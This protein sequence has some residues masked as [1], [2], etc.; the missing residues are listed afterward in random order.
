MCHESLNICGKR[1]RLHYVTVHSKG[2]EYRIRV[3]PGLYLQ[4]RRGSAKL[5]R[6]K[7]FSKQEITLWKRIE[8]TLWAWL[9]WVLMTIVT[10]NITSCYSDKW[11]SH[12]QT[13]VCFVRVLLAFSTKESL[14][15]SQ[16]M[17]V[18]QWRYNSSAY[19]KRCTYHLCVHD[20]FACV[21]WLHNVP[22]KE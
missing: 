17:Y 8:L 15:K 12:T 21:E 7:V 3:V 13:A 5:D 22:C 2:H 6:T 18:T 14:I 19:F 16:W 11:R 1:I 10:L 4:Y 20:V 9:I